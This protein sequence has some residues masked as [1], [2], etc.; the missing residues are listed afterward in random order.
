MYIV[1]I[2]KQRNTSL[3]Y[4]YINGK[5]SLMP[6]S[7][8]SAKHSLDIAKLYTGSNPIDIIEKNADSYEIGINERFPL[9]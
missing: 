1:K 3:Y 6:I 2:R 5:R 4:V 8:E 9:I 7:Y